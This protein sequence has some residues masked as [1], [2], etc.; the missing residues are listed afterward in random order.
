MAINVKYYPQ[1]FTRKFER[2]LN[3]NM[4]TAAE[5]LQLDIQTAFPGRGG[6]PSQPGEIPTVQTGDLKKSIRWRKGA[7]EFSRKIGSIIK[8]YPV[9]L[10]YGTRKISKRPYLRPAID[11]NRNTLRLYINKPMP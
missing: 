1:A 10:E 2:H 5:F 7:K 11:R 4:D 9:Y 3:T 6:V 8:G